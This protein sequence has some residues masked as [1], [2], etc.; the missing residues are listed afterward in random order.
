MPTRQFDLSTAPLDGRVLIESSAGTGKTFSI[1]GLFC[2]LVVE[3]DI[4]IDRILVVT[5]T[6]KATMELR[7]K[8]VRVLEGSLRYIEGFDGIELPSF[9]KDIIDRVDVSHVRERLQLALFN[10]HRARIYTI[11]GFCQRVLSEYSLETG[12]LFDV[13]LEKDSKA[14]LKPLVYDFWSSRIEVLP[15]DIL[16]LLNRHAGISFSYFTNIASIT[17][18]NPDIL[19]LP[20][21]LD[22]DSLSAL[23]KNSLEKGTVDDIVTRAME[24]KY[25]LVHEMRDFLRNRRQQL[26]LERGIRGYD[27]QISEVYH[28]RHYLAPVISRDYDALLIDEFQ[29]TDPMQYEI[30]ST[31]FKEIPVHYMIGDPKQAIYSFRGADLHA[32][33]KARDTGDAKFYTMTRNYRSHPRLLQALNYFYHQASAAPFLLDAIPYIEVSAGRDDVPALEMDGTPAPPMMLVEI[34]SSL[35][36]EGAKEIKTEVARSAASAW[37]VSEIKALLA[38]G[39]FATGDTARP[40]RYSDIAILLRKNKEAADILSDLEAA[41]IPAVR[42]GV[43]SVFA[44]PVARYLLRLLQALDSPAEPGILPAALATPLFGYRA[45]FLMEGLKNDNEFIETVRRFTGYGDLWRIHGIT[46]ALERCFT[47]EKVYQRIAQ[48]PEGERMLLD[49]RHLTELLHGAEGTQDGTRLIRWYSEMCEPRGS[50]RD[51]EGRR[52]PDASNAVT[53]TTIHKSKG[54]EYPIVFIPHHFFN[55]VDSVKKRPS[56]SYHDDNGRYTVHLE[57]NLASAKEAQEDELL[58]EDLRLLYVALTRAKSRCYFLY[59]TIRSGHRCGAGYLIHGVK[60][61]TKKSA[62][63]SIN[64]PELEKTTLDLKRIAE[65]SDGTIGYSLCE[66]ENSIGK[67]VGVVPL[68][69]VAIASPPEK[70]FL[71]Q[72][73]FLTSFSSLAGG[74]A[75]EKDIHDDVQDDTMQEESLLKTGIDSRFLLPAGAST[76]LFLHSIMEEIPFSDEGIKTRDAVIEQRC[77]DEMPQWS[78]A[79]K[80]IVNSTLAATLAGTTSFQLS[81]IPPEDRLHEM[82]FYFSAGEMD[83]SLIEDILNRHVSA[84]FGNEYRFSLSSRPMPRTF[85]KGFIDLVFQKDGRY[86]I[87][88]WK[89]NHLGHRYEDYGYDSMLGA[90]HEH[91]YMLQYLLYTLALHRFLRHRIEGY[92][93]DIHFGSVFYVFMRGTGS[94]GS[95]IFSDRIP[96]ELIDELDV[97]CKEKPWTR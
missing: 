40:V 5:Y 2:R 35:A 6:E 52:I 34:S 62:L 82:E 74:A 90:M 9:M 51:D 25:A 93:Y 32:Y 31:L 87:L 97:H 81:Q 22:V 80:D 47:E 46:T 76:G 33:L 30:F 20:E 7:L 69:D 84:R 58:A 66:G 13:T 39:Q 36:A 91:S 75:P 72:L 21:T 70:P 68:H 14:L 50:L 60:A 85:V 61:S 86:H 37:C 79:V 94:E 95:G 64:K 92:D 27:D 17:V 41:G 26:K 53:V 89:S 54:L 28:H 63:A 78:Q 24:L 88:D 43:E 10:F 65:G 71:R 56:R 3:K 55:V 1:T 42:T 8:I 18:N 4:P 59:G 83:V 73:E 16:D 15:L 67:E 77:R 49:L 96:R 11:H 29:D 48:L 23:M 19:W 45:S 44:S 57:K 38:Q 12:S